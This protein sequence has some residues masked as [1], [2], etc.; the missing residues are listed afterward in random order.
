[1]AR[2]SLL[3]FSFISFGSLKKNKFIFIL[4]V[5]IFIALFALTASVLSIYF[6]NKIDKLESVIIKEETNHIVY[7]NWLNR[8]PK[9]INEIN[10]ILDLKYQTSNFTPLIKF[11]SDVPT[12]MKSTGWEILFSER[13]ESFNY[14]YYYKGI[15]KFNFSAITSSLSDA[16]IVS[17]SEKDIRSIANERLKRNKLFVRY[18]KILSEYRYQQN[19]VNSVN[20]LSHTERRKYYGE[21]VKFQNKLKFI[22]IE[23][24]DYFLN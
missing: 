11:L 13:D 9:I 3:R 15:A 17:T 20:E 23:Q 5:A 22:L 16:V 8:E 19:S 2:L 1:M 12:Q 14:F 24:R 10:S 7:N 6:E 21:Y 18:D 4:N